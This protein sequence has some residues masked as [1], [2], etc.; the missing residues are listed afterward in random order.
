MPSQNWGDLT[1]SQVDDE[2]VE[3][4]ITRLVE[5]HNNN[6]EA[7]LAVGQSLQSHKAFEIIDHLAGS[8]VEDKIGDGEISSRCIT[9][10]QIIGKDFRTA[11]DVGVGAD[12][13]KMI[14][15]GI[16][17]WQ[18]GVQKVGIPIS[19][20]AFFRGDVE[21]DRLII[22]GQNT[23]VS[24]QSLD[25]FT[26]TGGSAEVGPGSLF[27]AGSSVD[28]S[29][30][31]LLANF[32]GDSD[33]VFTVYTIFQLPI[34]GVHAGVGANELEVMWGVGDRGAAG[35]GGYICFYEH[36]GVMKGR[37]VKYYGD[38]PIQCDIAGS[39]FGGFKN[40]RIEILN[41]YTVNFYINSE[42]VGTISTDISSMMSGPSMFVW[43]KNHG[44]GKIPYLYLR[45]Y[46][47]YKNT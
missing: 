29:E 35:D 47:F 12:G 33:I 24:W 7:H 4:A 11:S 10:D 28:H 41:S 8:I 3:E 18:G 16:E 44:T 31:L 15:A 1:K 42:L 25:A 17:M 6:E 21:I 14:P 20:N 43:S 13:V 45:S 32:G 26:L 34:Y 30:L 19:G 27:L 40:Y 38:T 37:V 46:T 2:L 23:L 36:N 22:N 9:T 5:V 39:N